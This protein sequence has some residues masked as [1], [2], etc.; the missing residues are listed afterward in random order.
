MSRSSQRAADR[1]QKPRTNGDT[2]SIERLCVVTVRSHSSGQV[3]LRSIA[4]AVG[5]VRGVCDVGGVA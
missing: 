2:I 1:R 5:G 4:A 3:A